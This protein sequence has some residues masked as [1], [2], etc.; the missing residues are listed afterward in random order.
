MSPQVAES[1]VPSQAGA[2]PPAGPA[3]PQTP[4][5]GPVPKAIAAAIAVALLAVGKTAG[6]MV[7]L[8]F[9]G[10]PLFAIMGGGAALFDMDGVGRGEVPLADIG[11]LVAAIAEVMGQRLLVA[12]QRGAVAVAPGLG[13]IE[14]GLESRAGRAAD[15]LAGEGVLDEHAR[16]R[17]AV[18]I[19]RQPRG[20][21]VH[22][23]RIPA[24]LVGEED[25][26]VGLSG[27]G[28]G[29]FIDVTS[30]RSSSPSG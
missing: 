19:R 15:W 10:I 18:E 17:H 9:L 27:H 5:L 28:R 25:D 16:L 2:P 23:D 13:R 3:A 14:A 21:P 22:A 29:P 8:A 4:K 26:D 30:C 1:R 6:A 7:L 12:R 24:L 11:R 20:V